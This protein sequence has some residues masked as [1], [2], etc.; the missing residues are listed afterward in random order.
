MIIQCEKCQTKFRFN[1]T[2][3]REEG[4]WLR[5]SQCKHVFF[6]DNPE[7]P[8]SF[9]KTDQ[10]DLSKTETL[11]GDRVEVDHEPS[12]QEE[13]TTKPY[14][15][16]KYFDDMEMENEE[17]NIY[18]GKVYGG[19]E[20]KGIGGR[21]GKLVAYAVIAVLIII[22]LAIWTF[23]PVGEKV[24]Q[25]LT[26]TQEYFRDMTGG[27]KKSDQ[28]NLSQMQITNVKQRY[29]NNLLVGR[30]RVVEGTIVNQ[31]K[32]YLANIKVRGE[33]VDANGIAMAQKESYVGNRFTDE[34]LMIKTEDEMLKE[35]S[36]P[37]GS[38]VSNERVVPSSQVPFMIIFIREP[39]GVA[40]ATVTLSG[41]ERLLP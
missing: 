36:N 10:D 5:C 29:M 40:K 2:L 3:L 7:K 4:I 28:F 11:K 15:A 24:F 33:L 32:F 38:D 16:P 35:L 14:G 27:D 17:D 9:H 31:S 19:R 25:G 41:A 26:S 8:S 30:I 21:I 34:E 1:E 39:D 13:R 23:P 37:L 6:K 18:E 12:F 22:I 20:E